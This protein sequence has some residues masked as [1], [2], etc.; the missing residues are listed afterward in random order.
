M[1]VRNKPD[2]LEKLKNCRVIEGF[3][4]IL[5]MDNPE[6]ESFENYTFPLLTEITDFL[7]VY[8]VTGLKSLGRLFPNLAVIRGNKLFLNYAL[9]VFEVFTLEEVG[10]HSLKFIGRGAVR[11]EK[12]QALCFSQSI[13]WSQLMNE[14]HHEGNDFILNRKENECPVCPGG[15]SS[16]LRNC[17]HVLTYPKK[18]YACWNLN[19]CQVVCPPQ[20]PYNC[21]GMGK[22]CDKS[23]L[24]GCSLGNPR[25]CTSCRHYS[26]G[27]RPDRRCIDDCPEP[28]I[29]HMGRRC[30]TKTE[31]LSIRKPIQSPF[32]MVPKPY[33]PFARECRLE[34][35]ESYQMDRE[36]RTCQPCP[37]TQCKKICVG[38]KI[39][40]ISAAQRMAD[41]QI[42]TGTL[43]IQIRREGGLSVVNELERF[44][45]K[46]E[47]IEGHLKISRSDPLVS[48]SFLKNLKEISGM[49]SDGRPKNG[50]EPSFTLTENENLQ[51]LFS[52]NQTVRILNGMLNF[53]TNPKLCVNRI[54]T[55]R[56]MLDN[57]TVKFD[58]ES[59]RSSNGDRVACDQLVLEPKV[60]KLV[61]RAATVQ[62]EPLEN[63]DDERSLL[64]YVIHYKPAPEENVTLFDGRDAC[65]FDGWQNDDIGVSKD[66][67]FVLTH[68]EPY[69]K[70]AY[71]VKTVQLASAQKGGESTIKYFTTLPD[72]PMIV[73]NVR[74][75]NSEDDA[76]TLVWDAPWKSHGN[77]TTYIITATISVDNE[78]MLKQRNYCAQS[79]YKKGS[80]RGKRSNPTDHFTFFQNGNKISTTH[81]CRRLHRRKSSPIRPPPM[82][83]RATARRSK[84]C[85]RRRRQRT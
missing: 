73:R 35:P 24:G 57:K 64:G 17:P 16:D 13:D 81:R 6:G 28:Y 21:D 11:I 38:A 15:N 37:E 8:R 26:L 43:E 40:S 63:L 53:H 52:E 25:N 48:L 71:Y 60:D 31:C 77:L 79:E 78:E 61:S 4:Q 76:L 69:T 83:R 10:L 51:N 54:E 3:L 85:K 9:V 62:F 32:D 42:I 19:H 72:E 22:C 55:L 23:C 20:C 68:L 39:D 33:I 7:L 18:T 84:S 67:I 80:T 50:N 1:D 14:T 44:L 2:Q 34:C 41:C 58:L 36:N 74:V 45:S 75:K 47:K 56:P 66:P 5:L 82:S 59:F 29:K 49:N 12:N 65:G 70:Y 27:N 30:I 46:I